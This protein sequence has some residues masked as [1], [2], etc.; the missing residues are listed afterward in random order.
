MTITM[1]QYLEQSGRTAHQPMVHRVR[2]DDTAE[3]G[4]ERLLHA[5]LG[6]CTEAGE[7]ADIV[8]GERYYQKHIVREHVLEELGDIL[9][10][11]GEALRVSGSTFEEVAEINLRKLKQRYPEKFTAHAAVNRDTKA[12]A[13]AMAGGGE[14]K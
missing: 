6:C 14:G 7:L 10:Y 5:A 3:V 2:K 11:V 9:W 13:A 12:E 4:R 8:K 1:E